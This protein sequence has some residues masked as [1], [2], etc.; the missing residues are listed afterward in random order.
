MA[1]TQIQTV[2]I[3]VADQDRALAFYR[4]LLG[5]P[6]RDDQDFGEGMRWLTVGAPG[7]PVSLALSLPQPDDPSWGTP[8]GPTG[9]AIRSD[10]LE[11]DHRRL[12][13]A[14]VR[15]DGPPRREE[16]GDVSA[17]MLD[18]DGNSFYVIQEGAR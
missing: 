16:W 8:G 12:S 14:G 3:L 2:E 9:L 7:D 18:P 1:L 17:T 6:V 10:D 15:F 11:A 13:A 5:W 4:D